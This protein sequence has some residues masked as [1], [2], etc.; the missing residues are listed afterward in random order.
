MDA[1]A[2]V[3]HR[4]GFFEQACEVNKES[5]ILW[6]QLYEQ[7]PTQYHDNLVVSV[8]LQAEYLRSVGQ[9][10]EA[11]AICEEID[12]LDSFTTDSEDE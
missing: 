1:Y 6:T 8:G 2:D 4:R 7:D 11:D 5:L 3:L 12:T 10:G 9:V